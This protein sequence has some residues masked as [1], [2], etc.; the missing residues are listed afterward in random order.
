MAYVHPTVGNLL[1]TGTATAVITPAAAVTSVPA[2]TSA[3]AAGSAPTK[4]EFDKVVVDL[5]A[6]RTTI[7]DLLTKLHAGG[8]LA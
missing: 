4:A 7:N 6:A 2:L 3:A 1:R 5:A 8:F